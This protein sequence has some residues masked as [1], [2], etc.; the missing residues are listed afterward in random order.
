MKKILLLLLLASECFAGP[1]PITWNGAC[2][3][4]AYNLANQSCFSSGG[5]SVNSVT[6]SAPLS[7]SLGA[8]PNLSIPAGSS[9]ANGYISSSDWITFNGKQ[10]GPLTGDVTTL[11]AVAT[12]GNSTVTNIKIANSTIDLT[13]KVTGVLP[14]ANGGT[15][16]NSWTQG[17]IVFADG[18]SAFGEDNSNFFWD[19]TAKRAYIGTNPISSPGDNGQLNLEQQGASTDH[20][21]NIICRTTNNCIELQAQ[22]ANVAQLNYINDVGAGGASITLARARGTITAK[23][24]MK[25]GDVFG[26]LFFQGYTGT[27]F[28]GYGAAIAAVALQDITSSNAGSELVFAISKNGT[29]AAGTNALI[30]DNNGDSNFGGEALLGGAAN[31]SNALIVFKNGHYKS[32]QTTAPTTAVN[33]NAGTGASCTVTNAT[34]QAGA[35]TITFGSA[36]FSSGDQCDVNF[37]KAYNVAPICSI[38]PANASAAADMGSNHQVYVGGS[39]AYVSINYGLAQNS[40]G[41]VNTWNYRCM[42]T[43]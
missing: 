25:A 16:K 7:S 5:G 33:S 21:E 14:W 12:I 24:Q 13:A 20:A 9:V 11:G 41:Q 4:G 19:N 22:N 10:A 8:N 39:T 31:A 30:L 1:S 2:A 3:S 29:N 37:N 43:Q 17:S 18:A 40:A 6:A 15:N 34:D 23:T 38:T 26:G 27:S 42:E 35:V 36:A 32:T 28:T